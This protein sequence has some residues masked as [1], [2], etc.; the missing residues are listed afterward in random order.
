MR[1]VGFNRKRRVPR[2]Y[3]NGKLQEMLDSMGK[4]D[5]QGLI[6]T[7]NSTF[8]IFGLHQWEK[9]KVSWI[10]HVKNGN[11]DS[12]QWEI[13][14]WEKMQK[15]LNSMRKRGQPG[16]HF[17]GK[18]QVYNTW[19]ISVGINQKRLNQGLIS[20]GNILARN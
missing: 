14:G 6:S 4:G 5:N 10:Q 16:A 11:Q 20:M 8:I 15:K 2:T 9:F 12:F 17:N 3:F 1:E 7:G 13:T 19:L 18:S